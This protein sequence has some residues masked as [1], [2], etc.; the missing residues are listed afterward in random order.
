MGI[1]K[2]AK[3]A[4]VT[5]QRPDDGGEDAVGFYV[6]TQDGSALTGNQIIEAI[7]EAIL[8]HWENLPMERWDMGDFDA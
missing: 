5:I 6:Y 3:K 7:A 8:L 1:Q 2:V 4:H